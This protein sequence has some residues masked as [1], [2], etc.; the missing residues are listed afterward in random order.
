MCD[1]HGCGE[2]GGEGC[3]VRVLFEIV[4]MEKGSA[5]EVQR[6]GETAGGN[7]ECGI[8]CESPFRTDLRPIVAA[9]DGMT[10]ACGFGF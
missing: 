2:N 10:G 7:D 3:A 4:G 5:F 9:L 6:S 8:A 1:D